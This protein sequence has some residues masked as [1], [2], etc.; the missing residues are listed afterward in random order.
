MITLFY[1]CAGVAI[2]FALASIAMLLRGLRLLEHKPPVSTANL[3]PW[4]HICITISWTL[5]AAMLAI[6]IMSLVSQ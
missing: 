2:L 5:I 1:V 6:G 3:G 4:S